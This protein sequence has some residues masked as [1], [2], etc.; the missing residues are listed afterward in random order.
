M[1]LIFF[2]R[3]SLI[4]EDIRQGK[5]E[6]EPII[7][8][9]HQLK[10]DGRSG[11]DRALGGFFLVDRESDLPEGV[12]I[13]DVVKVVRTITDKRGREVPIVLLKPHEHRFEPYPNA[14]EAQ[15][16]CPLCRIT[17]SHRAVCPNRHCEGCGMEMTPAHRFER[18]V[19]SFTRAADGGKRWEDVEVW[20]CVGCSER[21]EFV[22]ETIPN[23]LYPEKTFSTFEELRDELLRYEELLPDI[24][25]PP[26]KPQLETHTVIREDDLS[27]DELSALRRSG[28]RYEVIGEEIVELEVGPTDWDDEQIYP[29]LVG[30]RTEPRTVSRKIYTVRVWEE[31]LTPKSELELQQWRREVEKW[32]GK[33][34]TS[35]KVAI[36]AAIASE[37]TERGTKEWVKEIGEILSRYSAFGFAAAL[38][39]LRGLEPEY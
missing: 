31:E 29:T 23:P 21:K 14:P 13:F 32:A 19:G 18:F 15:H 10:E 30:Y 28:K 7:I 24:P 33:L 27:S 26:A 22:T 3:D 20:E 34:S 17:Q 25:L 16:W 9:R 2:R 8:Y 12:E 35:D 37:K 5:M 36:A 4:K 11:F 38:R 1:R 39:R 6:G